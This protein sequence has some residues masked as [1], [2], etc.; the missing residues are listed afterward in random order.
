MRPPQLGSAVAVR[1]RVSLG[2]VIGALTGICRTRRAFCFQATAA[3]GLAECAS[4]YFFSTLEIACFRHAEH[5]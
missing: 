4:S 2:I 3:R 5:F 1:L